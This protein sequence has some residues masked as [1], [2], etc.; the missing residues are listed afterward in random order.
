[1]YVHNTFIDDISNRTQAEVIRFVNDFC[2]LDD[3]EFKK[4]LYQRR[5]LE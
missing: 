3:D 4:D 1:M 5:K 2:P